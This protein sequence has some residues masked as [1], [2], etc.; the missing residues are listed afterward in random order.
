MLEKRE[1]LLSLLVQ[2]ILSKEESWKKAAGTIGAKRKIQ[3]KNSLVA[4]L[5]RVLH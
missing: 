5:V 1:V 4:Q 2:I 3:K